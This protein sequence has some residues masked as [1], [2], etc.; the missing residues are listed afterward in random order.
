VNAV[1]PSLVATPMAARAANDPVIRDFITRKQPL[2][3]EQLSSDN[4]VAGYVYLIENSAVTGQILE[5]DGGW[6]TVSGV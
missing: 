3:G 5:I 4:V 2:I 6:S 1:S